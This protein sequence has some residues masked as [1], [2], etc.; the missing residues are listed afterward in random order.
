MFVS[1]GTPDDDLSGLSLIY[2]VHPDVAGGARPIGVRARQ[3]PRT[4]PQVRIVVNGLLDGRTLEER[5]CAGAGFT[6]DPATCQDCRDDPGTVENESGRCRDVNNDRVPDMARL[7]SGMATIHC[8]GSFEYVTGPGDG[9]YDASGNQVVS[10]YGLGGLGP[11]I[12][13]EPRV[14]LPPNADCRLDLGPGV[15][16]LEGHAL[17]WP[18]GGVVFHTA[19]E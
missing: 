12:V 13:I 6:R 11:A 2:D 9:H 19:V 16:D 15:K 18:A 8:L 7:I 14:T 3:V 1:N 5:Q 17:G 4:T 10:S